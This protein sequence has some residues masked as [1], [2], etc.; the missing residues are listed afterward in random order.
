M[1]RTEPAAAARL[2]LTKI[3]AMSLL[4]AVVEPGLNPNQP[5]QRINTPRAARGK[6]WP[7]IGLI[8]PS[9]VYL[10]IRGPR[11]MA[12]ARA[13]QPPTECTTVE[14][15]KS[16]KPKPSSQPLPLNRLPQAQLPKTG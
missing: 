6:L 4:A 8:L 12:P 11:T 14:P 2:V 1:A 9:L 13:A 15:A 3:M 16:M 5:S 7:K 10:P